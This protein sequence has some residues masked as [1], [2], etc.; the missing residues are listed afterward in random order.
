MKTNKKITMKV[1][2]KIVVKSAIEAI[3]GGFLLWPLAFFI[4]EENWEVVGFLIV[5][6]YI[7]TLAFA[8][9]HRRNNGK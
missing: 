2:S 8:L 9:I 1:L 5:L 6:V 4:L 7:P 3:I